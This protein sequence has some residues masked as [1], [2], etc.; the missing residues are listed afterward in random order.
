MFGPD[1]LD[2]TVGNLNFYSKKSAS[3]QCPPESL[4]SDGWEITCGNSGTV[5]S[6]GKALYQTLKFVKDE[7]SNQKRNLYFQIIIKLFKDMMLNS[8]N[9]QWSQNVPFSRSENIPHSS[10]AAN[11]C[12][13][14]TELNCTEWID[15]DIPELLECPE[16]IDLNCTKATFTCANFTDLNCKE[17]IDQDIPE[18]LECP[19]FIDL[20][21]TNANFTCAN[22]TDLNC[23]EWIDLNVAEVLE[24]PQYIDLNCNRTME[25]DL[26]ITD[27]NIDT[28]HEEIDA[29][30]LNFE[31]KFPMTTTF[32]SELA[33]K[34]S[35][36]YKS[37]AENIE[38]E[39]RPGLENTA[40]SYRLKNYNYI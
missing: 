17:W 31:I 5:V 18:L 10:I 29:V 16:F 34:N 15:L 33:D 39:I 1:D 19:E 20:N 32:T 22:F 38:N 28:L 12:S 4:W 24:C 2:T 27:T 8:Y 26:N 6:L 23:T 7:K 3:S 9:H 13:N 21:C 25:N 35:V 11:S 30:R 37:A 14:Y 40:Q 36:Q